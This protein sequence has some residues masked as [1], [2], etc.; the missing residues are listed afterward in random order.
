MNK[1]A[2]VRQRSLPQAVIASSMGTNQFAYPIHEFLHLAFAGLLVQKLIL[3][4]SQFRHYFKALVLAKRT[5][6]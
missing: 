2:T 6:N 5:D 4:A 3:K 1:R